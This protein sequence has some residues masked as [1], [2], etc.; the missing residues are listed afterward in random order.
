MS[1]LGKGAEHWGAF[2]AANQQSCDR[3]L[4]RCLRGISCPHRRAELASEYRYCLARSLARLVEQ[5]RLTENT[6]RT[7]A[8]T[9]HL[10]TLRRRAR[11]D[12]GRP[13]G[14]GHVGPWNAPVRQ[15]G[16]R[17]SL[18]VL[19]LGSRPGLNPA[20]L[21]ADR[22][23]LT[24]ALE[25]GDEVQQTAIAALMLGYTRAEAA[26]VAGWNIATLFR[27]LAILRAEYRRLTG[28]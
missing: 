10:R 8:W 21:A 22:E 16:E 12:R 1:R 19:D 5:G 23:L 27:R 17:V 28:E 11:P 9:A 14:R 4:W 25:Q 15:L 26:R 2:Y 3:F 13:A 20:A 7:A 24:W 18:D 6:L